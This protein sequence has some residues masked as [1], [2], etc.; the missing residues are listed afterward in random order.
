MFTLYQ[1]RSDIFNKPT[2]QTSPYNEHQQYRNIWLTNACFAL[3]N[4]LL[5]SISAPFGAESSDSGYP[6]LEWSPA[7]LQRPGGAI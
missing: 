7:E 3:V 1:R 6:S 2:F 5:T 4:F